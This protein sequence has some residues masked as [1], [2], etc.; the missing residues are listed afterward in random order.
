[1]KIKLHLKTTSCDLPFETSVTAETNYTDKRQ[2]PICAIV[3]QLMENIEI[4]IEKQYGVNFEAHLEEEAKRAR[5]IARINAT[6]A[7]RQEQDM[8]DDISA[9]L[10]RLESLADLEEGRARLRKYKD[11]PA[12]HAEQD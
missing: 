11:E 12:Y 5:L 8:R 3:L 9:N 10:A 7:E 4:A 1:M 2:F 6:R